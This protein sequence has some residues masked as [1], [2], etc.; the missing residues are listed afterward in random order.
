MLEESHRRAYLAALQVDC[1]LPRVDLPY[2]APARPLWQP[3]VV[4]DK[5]CAPATLSTPEAPSPSAPLS[6]RQSLKKSIEQKPLATPSVAES[7]SEPSAEPVPELVA[8][9][10]TVQLAQ[11]GACL[12][13]VELPTGEPLAGRDPAYLLLQDLLRAARLEGNL[14]WLGEPLRW[15]LLSGG[16][17]PQGPQAASEY[18]HS[19]LR[20]QHEHTQYRCTWLI[21]LPALRFVA[22]WDEADYGRLEHHE[23][24]GWL[25]AVPSLEL[26]M[27]QPAHKKTLWQA[28]QRSMSTWI[29]HEPSC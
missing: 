13:V 24:C 28:M 27:E 5:A 15:P 23:S 8:P 21:G 3:P 22:H 14:R 26:L 6:L 16:G 29:T 18:L 10:F 11:A 2:A 7:E 12:L 1:W 19:L 4:E 9:R 17:L 25:W 20:V